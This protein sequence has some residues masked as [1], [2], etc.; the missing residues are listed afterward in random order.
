M[1]INFK[2]E[3]TKAAV[4]RRANAE[5]WNAYSMISE[6][7]GLGFGVPVIPGTVDGT[8]IALTNNADKNILGITE[9]SAVIPSV[10]STADTYSAGD[11]VAIC[12]AG[13]IGVSLAKNVEAG[14]AARWNVA[15]AAWTDAGAASGVVTVPGA[16]FVAGGKSGGVGVIRYRRPVPSLSAV[17]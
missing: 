12:E 4:G 16:E 10:G 13:V 5:N 17:S 7:A 9:A 14:K 1:G 3:I 2:T 8:C 11:T 6:V 15:G